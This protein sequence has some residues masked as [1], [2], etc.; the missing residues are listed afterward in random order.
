MKASA[1]S[2]RKLW[3]LD[4]TCALAGAIV[5]WLMFDFLVESIGLPRPLVWAQFLA[6][7][8]Y[9]LFGVIAFAFQT[10]RVEWFRL[11]VTMNWIYACLC[12]GTCLTLAWTGNTTGATLLLLE[13]MMIA[14][15]A[16][17]ERRWMQ[18][19][20]SSQLLS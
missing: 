3:V 9:G 19:I 2:L 20:N 7:L 12:F 4:F 14:T 11:L 16:F 18:R 5:F 13:G 1:F 8:F 6:N 10:E 17:W 15:L